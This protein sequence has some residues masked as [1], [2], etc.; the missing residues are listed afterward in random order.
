MTLLTAC[1]SLAYDVGLDSPDVVV[2]SSDRTWSVALDLANATGEELARRVD[3]PQL[4]DS[5]TLTGDGAN[6]AH[7]LP[8]TFMRAAPGAAV[9]TS[10]GAI[11]RKA[12][13]EEWRTL[14]MTEGTPRYYYIGVSGT[15]ETY[16]A[17][18]SL[19]PYL[20]NAATAT[21]NYQSSAFCEGGSTFTAD[22][23]DIYI[24]ED[25][26]VKGLV[27]RWRRQH[28]MD[29]ADYEAEYEAALADRAASVSGL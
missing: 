9:F 14:T 13:G 8:V 18:M 26:F 1:Q 17:A 20:A 25:L 5:A 27:V 6:T 28:G 7:D 24:D 2:T 23:D 11:I 3:W 19:W 15:P 4:R 21:V 16:P 12:S 22:T 10:A 29:Y